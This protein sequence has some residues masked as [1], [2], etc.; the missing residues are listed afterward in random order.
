MLDTSD[1]DEVPF[2]DLHRAHSGVQGDG[3][4]Y[5]GWA[6]CAV[7]HAAQ[8]AAFARRFNL[9]SCTA[10]VATDEPAMSTWGGPKSRQ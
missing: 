1:N 2:Y 8:N 10:V 6:L 3:T 5:C 4:A 9:A 7:H